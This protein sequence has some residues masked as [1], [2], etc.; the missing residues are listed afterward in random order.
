MNKPVV[1]IVGRPNVG[2]STLFNRLIQQKKAI[3]DATPGVTRDRNYGNV[4]WEGIEWTLID[5]GGIGSPLEEKFQTLIKKQVDVAIGEADLILFLCDAKDGL[6]WQDTTISHLLLKT[7]KNTLLVINKLDNLNE[8]LLADFYR[9]GLGEP[10]PIS[11]LHGKN[12]N[13]LLDK[14]ITYL[15]PYQ[16]EVEKTQPVSV[17]I[18]GKPNVGKSSIL[19]AILGQERAIVD[20]VPG[21]TRDAIDTLFKK[22]NIPFLFIDTAGIR[23][24][25]KVRQELEYYSVVRAIKSIRRADVVLLVI[26][27][28]EGISTQD[29]K[30]TTEMES[31]GCSGIIVINKWDLATDKTRPKMDEYKKYVQKKIPYL[32]H[33][34]SIFTS[35]I[36]RQGISKLLMLIEQV[37][38]EHKKWFSTSTLNKIINLTYAQSNPPSLKGKTLKIY[39]ATQIATSPPT[40]ILFV[41]HPGLVSPAYL[42]YLQTQIRQ[43]LDLKATPIHLKFKKRPH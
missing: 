9:L 39:Y 33:L 43:R 26:D 14:I 17:A 23:K 20:D 3:V 7:Q 11:A 41:N 30:I 15:L 38:Q 40:F 16:R 36:T 5:T 37:G 25:S 10:I 2:K 18:I 22:G 42:R 29:K 6:I 35:A 19:N 31:V 34:P 8:V 27:A 21:T 32:S 1:A 24:K 4:D 28:I 13:T 12:I